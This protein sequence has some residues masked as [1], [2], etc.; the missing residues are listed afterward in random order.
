MPR[1][2]VVENQLE[3]FLDRQPGTRSKHPPAGRLGERPKEADLEL[4]LR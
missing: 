1:P 3:H 2:R 4:H